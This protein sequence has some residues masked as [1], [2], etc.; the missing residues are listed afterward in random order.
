MTIGFAARVLALSLVG[1]FAVPLP[2]AAQ[3]VT[4]EEATAAQ[5]E[6]AS[7]AFREGRSAFDERRFS[8]A[9]S[10]FRASYE[11]VAS[12]NTHLMIAHSLRELG[13][14]AEAYETFG[15][16]ALEAERAAAD[17]PKYE[18]TARLAREEQ[19]RLRD[20]IAL[21]TLSLPEVGSDATL[22]VA[23]RSIPRE[24]WRDPIAVTPGRVEIVLN[25]GGK[26]M[27]ESIAVTAGGSESVTV[28]PPIH[29]DGSGV[30]DDGGGSQWTGTQR[31][32]AYAVAG[33]GVVSLVAAAATGGM[34]LS[35]HDELE[36]ACG[37]MP[38]PD[39]QGDIDEGRAFQTAS[40]VTLIFGLAAVGTGIVLFLTAPD[41]EPTGAEARLELGPASVSL[42]GRF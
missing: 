30:E 33:V 14:D 23:G 39:R 27:V 8:D 7:E 1:L 35:K 12:P 32:V 15:R 4:P 16:V 3:G 41:D 37:G 9:L 19:E 38:C 13:R 2:T 11:V 17:S 25:D 34:A 20:G 31:Y 29:G 10:G 40:N 28:A 22:T 24:R 21:V 5:K 26:S 6:R 36:A 42:R 18:E